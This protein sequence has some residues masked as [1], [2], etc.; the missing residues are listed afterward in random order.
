MVQKE[1][2]FMLLSQN[3]SIRKINIAKGIHRATISRY[4]KKYQGFSK[5]DSETPSQ[6]SESQ[7]SFNLIQNVPPVESKVPTDKV[8]HFQVPDDTSFP[9]RY[10][11]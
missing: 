1:L 5:A 2:I 3:W 8:V 4:K 10:Y 7:R 9:V 11:S 6:N